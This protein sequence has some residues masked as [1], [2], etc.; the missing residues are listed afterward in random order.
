LGNFLVG[1]ANLER[2]KTHEKS[3]WQFRYELAGSWVFESAPDGTILFYPHGWGRAYIVPTPEKRREIEEFLAGWLSKLKATLR[4]AQWGMAVVLVVFVTPLVPRFDRIVW[5]VPD[6]P[7]V[8]RGT[9]HLGIL[10]LLLVAGCPLALRCIAETAK[11]DLEKASVR[12]PLAGFLKE[13]ARRSD[14]LRLSTEG[15]FYTFVLIAAIWMLWPRRESIMTS[16]QSDPRLLLIGVFCIFLG[17]AG[18]LFKFWRIRA[19]LRG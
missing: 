15:A 12:R 14:S 13:Q 8:L 5:S 10:A 7:T 19:K 2:A 16:A 18:V 17:G 9:L 11:A 6:W 4:V 1:L 3:R